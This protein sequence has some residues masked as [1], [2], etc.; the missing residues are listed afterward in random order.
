MR[1]FE[2]D[3]IE[4]AAA[5]DPHAQLRVQRRQDVLQFHSEKRKSAMAAVIAKR[6]RSLCLMTG[7]VL[8]AAAVARAC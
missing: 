7:N 5:G 3:D 8:K 1:Q 6:R 4:K 2:K